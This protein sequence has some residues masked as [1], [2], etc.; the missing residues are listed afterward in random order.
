M[1][2]PHWNGAVQNQTTGGMRGVSQKLRKSQKELFQKVFEG[3][4][5]QSIGNDLI[6]DLPVVFS[7]SLEEGF[8]ALKGKIEAGRA[9]SH[10]TSQVTDRCVVKT[11]AP[12]E[13]GGDVQGLVDIKFAWASHNRIA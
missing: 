8:L 1:I 2:C 5:T 3:F 7:N 10:G 11:F 13:I 12:K 9:D 4:L 6:L